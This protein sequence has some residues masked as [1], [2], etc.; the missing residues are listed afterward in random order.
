MTVTPAAELL[1]EGQTLRKTCQIVTEDEAVEVM[2]TKDGV[3]VSSGKNDSIL[4][5]LSSVVLCTLTIKFLF[6]L[7]VALFG[8]F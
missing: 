8:N 2:W 6:V 3:E 4:I 5:A 7:L 1:D